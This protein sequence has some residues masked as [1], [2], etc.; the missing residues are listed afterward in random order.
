[1]GELKS[2]VEP[3]L[4]SPRP[5]RCYRGRPVAT[6]DP[7]VD[8]FACNECA[9]SSRSSATRSCTCCARRWNGPPRPAGE[10]APAAGAR[11]ARAPGRF[12]VSGRR[13][14]TIV[15][16]SAQHWALAVRQLSLL[17]DPGG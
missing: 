16:R 9:C 13:V 5:K 7:S 4:S 10:P 8:A 3:A 17:P 12:T 14:T 15:G 1:M 2:V 11:H 6:H